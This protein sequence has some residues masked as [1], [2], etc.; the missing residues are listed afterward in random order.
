[1][2]KPK[3]LV[4]VDSGVLIEFLKPPAQR[5]YHE[6]VAVFE[7]YK[8]SIGVE[9]VIPE[10]VALEVLQ[11][12]RNKAEKDAAKRTLDHIVRYTAAKGFTC[13]SVKPRPSGRG[14]KRR[15][16]CV[17]G[18]EL[19]WCHENPQNPRQRQARQSA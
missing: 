1:M 2:P 4:L 18:L 15:S 5:R 9:L 14:C 13:C 6:A 19:K 3:R 11:G 12:T 8:T 7:S 10:I 16:G 17:G